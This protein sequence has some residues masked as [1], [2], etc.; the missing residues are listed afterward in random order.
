MITMLV[1]ASALAGAEIAVAPKLMTA[2]RLS[3]GPKVMLSDDYLVFGTSA[4][5]TLNPGFGAEGGGWLS[6]GFGMSHSVDVVPSGR[7]FD[8]VYVGGRLD[9]SITSEGAAYTN[10]MPDGQRLTGGVM[11]GKRWREEDLVVG[12]GAGV[13]MGDH[14]GPL[15][16]SIAG[17]DPYSA[18]LL[19]VPALELTIAYRLK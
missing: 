16:T 6:P 2:G 13:K 8:G 11:V 14:Y 4:A 5:V 10:F 1:A 7:G 18:H 19:P 12:M 17:G 15:V 3:L 9:W